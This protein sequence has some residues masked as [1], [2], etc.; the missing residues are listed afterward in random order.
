MNRAETEAEC[1]QKQQH[2]T[3]ENPDCQ[4]SSTTHK[5]ATLTNQKTGVLDTRG[6]WKTLVYQY[7]DDTT[8]V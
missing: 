4:H 5:N 3:P 6:E 1:M 2:R 7:R 8:I